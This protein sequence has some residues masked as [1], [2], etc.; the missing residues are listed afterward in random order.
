MRAYT[1]IDRASARLGNAYHER[2]WSA[3]M[4]LTVA[5]LDKTARF[6][7]LAAPS[8]SGE[9]IEFA[10][11]SRERLFQPLDF[12]SVEW[13]E[14]N[15]PMGATL[16]AR[17]VGQHVDVTIR[18]FLFHDKP[19]FVRVVSVAN[20]TVDILNLDKVMLDAFVLR[21]GVEFRKETLPQL[22]FGAP[23][24]PSGDVLS[25]TLRDYGMFVIPPQAF[26]FEVQGGLCSIHSDEPLSLSARQIVHFPPVL[27]LPYQPPLNLIVKS[28][29][30]DFIRMVVSVGAAERTQETPP[31]V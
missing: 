23:W 22:D 6:D 15:S 29:Y 11:S 28:Q 14:E 10:F 31:R 12:G 5:L 16:V 30:A 13:S 25:A 24:R 2:R 8:P 9:S 18:S 3:F 27:L 19:G 20:K 1:Y 4:G 21:A 17:W 26:H 7:W